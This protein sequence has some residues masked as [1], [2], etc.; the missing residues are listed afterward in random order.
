MFQQCYEGCRSYLRGIKQIH[1]ARAAFQGMRGFHCK[2]W[3]LPLSPVED[4]LGL[5]ST[6]VHRLRFVVEGLLSLFQW[7]TSQCL[8]Q[9]QLPFRTHLALAFL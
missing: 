2:G 6:L 5:C 9:L 8:D 4:I 1:S 7:E 3:C